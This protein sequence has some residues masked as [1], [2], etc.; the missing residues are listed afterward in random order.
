M[1]LDDIGGA[2]DAFPELNF[3]IVHGGMAFL[4]ET[5]MQLSL[6]PNVYVNSRP[7]GASGCRSGASR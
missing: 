4:D 2:A 1:C 5:G 7:R 3:E 6:F